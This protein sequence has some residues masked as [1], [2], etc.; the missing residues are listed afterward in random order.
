M[1]EGRLYPF[2]GGNAREFDTF[3]KKVLIVVAIVA[4]VLLLWSIRRILL[5]LAIAAALAAGIAPAVRRV[6]V[7]GRHYF[8]RK[9]PRGGAVL[10]VYLPFLLVI[11]TIVAMTLPQ[12]ISQSQ[13]MSRDLPRLIQERVVRPL[14]PYIS[15]DELQRA[16]RQFGNRVH[17]ETYVRGVATTITAIVA[18]LFLIVY[19]L[20][21]AE[22]LRNLFLLLFPAEQRARKRNLIR[23]VSRRMSSWLSGQLTLAAIIGATTFC[24]LLALRIPYALPLALIAAVGEM[25]PIIGPIIGAVPALAV[26][27]FQS[28]WQFW[29][30]LIFAVAVQQIENYLIVPRLM[31]RRVSISPLAVFVAFMIGASLLG[32]IGAIMA[33]PAAAVVQV[34]FEESFVMRRERRQNADRPGTLARSGS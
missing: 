27:A 19:I 22:R 25:V 31:A 3:A 8:R 17:L 1:K 10:I 7:L 33:I 12:L 30:V 29:A 11:G 20:I 2:G 15:A 6:Q 28:P 13:E 34:I 18:I 24:A 16:V 21:D 14:S 9:I 5:I 23:R 4:L 32:V 26:A